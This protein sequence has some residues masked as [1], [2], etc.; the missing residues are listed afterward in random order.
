MQLKANTLLSESSY[1]QPHTETQAYVGLL[2]S[3][4]IIFSCTKLIVQN[5]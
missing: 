2:V 4:N 5:E 1:K 3:T